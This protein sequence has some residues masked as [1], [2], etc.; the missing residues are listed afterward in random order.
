MKRILL[1]AALAVTLLPVAF[2]Q[3]MF[4]GNLTHTGVYDSEGPRQFKGVKWA[5]QTGGPVVSSPTVTDGAAYVGSDDRQLYAVNLA[6]GK[7][8]W[9][10]KS[11]WVNATPAVRDGTV[12][13]GTSI[14][15]FFIALDAATGKERYK[16]DA[17]VPV[18]SSPALAG[19]LAYFGSFSGKFYAVDVNDGMLA[20]QFQTEASAK[21]APMYLAA[22]GTINYPVVFKSNFFE[23][24]TR[25]GARLFE[26]GAIVSSP[27]V[28][29]GVV[30]VGSAD[31]NLYALE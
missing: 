10:Y 8:K 4:R 7:E 20:W 14:P 31:G 25:A 6:T 30:Y 27:V 9:K 12:Y 28:D 3:N 18:F 15:A 11:T 29:H 19:G 17:H 21:L 1:L 22:D 26:L 23:D 24:M 5:F 13:F 2:S 16:F